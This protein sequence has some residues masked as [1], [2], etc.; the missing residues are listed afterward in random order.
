MSFLR[1][2]ETLHVP[3]FLLHL[4]EAEVTSRREKFPNLKI[5]ELVGSSLAHFCTRQFV[6]SQVPKRDEGQGLVIETG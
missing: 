6:P 3:D 5:E 1:V 4:G 2:Q